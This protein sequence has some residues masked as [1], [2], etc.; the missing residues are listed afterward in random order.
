MDLL[1]AAAPETNLETHARGLGIISISLS[2][3]LCA[4]VITTG[5]IFIIVKFKKFR[6]NK[7]L[8][9]HR[10]LIIP[11]IPDNN[12]DHVHHTVSDMPVDGRNIQNSTDNSPYT[13]TQINS[14]ARP[15]TMNVQEIQSKSKTESTIKHYSDIKLIKE[16]KKEHLKNKD[17]KTQLLV[18]VDHL[19]KNNIDLNLSKQKLDT[20]NI[21]K[22]ND[23]RPISKNNNSTKIQNIP[24][25]KKT[26]EESAHV[27]N[28]NNA[29]HNSYIGT[30]CQT[31]IFYDT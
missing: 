12:N 5:I 4:L 2:S 28:I 19:D 29:P 15:K 22:N 21:N 13:V 11:E 30:E 18:Q 1:Q 17:N 23:I 9:H 26:T 16:P 6:K 3:T 7:D 14:G 8:E 24:S 31:D 20:I 10:P 25:V 27:N